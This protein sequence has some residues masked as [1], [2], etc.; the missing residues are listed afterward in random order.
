MPDQ[1]RLG[2]LAKADPH[3]HCCPACPHPVI[4]PI[5]QGSPDVLVNC[6]PASRKGDLGV[7]MPCCGPNVWHADAGSGTVFINGIEAYRKD[8]A[9]KHCFGAGSGKALAG[10][11]NVI[12]GD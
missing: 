12:T 9:S 5:V 11:P 3:G 10:S 8:D 7:A 1:H 2:D 6:L 4:G